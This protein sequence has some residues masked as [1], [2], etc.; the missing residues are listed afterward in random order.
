MV[1]EKVSDRCP[2]VNDSKDQSI[3]SIEVRCEKEQ[4][5]LLELWGRKTHLVAVG[6]SPIKWR[7]SARPFD[8]CQHPSVRN[9]P[10]C[11]GAEDYLFRSVV[12]I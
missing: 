4:E 9:P 11:A 10:R 1:T 12:Q 3:H 6:H 7:V 5:C 8:L 2:S